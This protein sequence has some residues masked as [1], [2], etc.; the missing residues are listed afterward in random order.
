VNRNSKALILGLVLASALA[1]GWAIAQEGKDSSS[2]VPKPVHVIAKG[3]KCVE[4]I[5]FMRKNH[6]EVLLHHRDRTM[7]QGIR[8]TQHSLKA[9]VEC[10][11]NPQTGSVAAGKEDFCQSC[12]AYAAVKIDCFE[13]HSTRPEAVAKRTSR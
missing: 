3:D 13:C 8:T 9:C 6:M 10:H 5:E 11:A 1:A 12:H 4:P 2:R 7:H